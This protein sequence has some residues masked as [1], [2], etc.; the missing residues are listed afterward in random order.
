MRESPVPDPLAADDDLPAFTTVPMARSRHDGWTSERQRGFIAALA[1]SG[2]VAKAARSVGMGPSSAYALRHR[3]GAESFVIAWDLVEYEARER[4]LAYVMDH[5]INGATRPRFYRGRFV[6]T[7][8]G[9][10]DRMVMAAL[11]AL[12]TLPPGR[13]RPPSGKV[14]ECSASPSTLPSPGARPG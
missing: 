12:G 4:A 11:R 6:S 10:E 5:V 7:V 2:I 3:P 13:S 9:V 1:Q 14:D 8:H